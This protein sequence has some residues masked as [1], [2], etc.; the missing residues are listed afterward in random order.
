MI[1]QDYKIHAE[2]LG[3]GQTNKNGLDR[4]MEKGV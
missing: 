1:L 3:D 2:G 4:K